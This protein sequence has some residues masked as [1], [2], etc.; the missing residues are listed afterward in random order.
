MRGIGWGILF[1]FAAS[2]ASADVET[3]VVTARPPD[4]VGNDAFS[5]AKIDAPALHAFEQLDRA[6]EQVPGLSEFRRDSCFSANPTTQGVSLRSIAPSGA[7]RTLV[8]LDG[9]PQ[10]DPFGGWVLWCSLPPEDI[11]A[12][13]VVR[14]AGAGPYG[15]GALTGTIAL[16]EADGAGLYAV[17]GSAGA[18]GLK[19]IAA[20]GGVNVGPLE[21]FGGGAEEATSGWTPVS[22]NQRGAADDDVSVDARNGSLRVAAAPGGGIEVSA[23]TSVYDESRHSGLVGAR[24]EASGVTASVTVLHPQSQGDLGWRL[25]GWLRDTDFANSSVSIGPLRAF[26]TPTNDEYATP[27]IGWGANGEL[28]GKLAGIDWA[29]GFD[30]RDASGETREHFNVAAGQFTM[31]RVAGGRTFVGGLYAEAANRFDGWLLTLGV[32]GDEWASTGGHLRQN[33]ISSGVVT[34]NQRFPSRS[35]EVFTAR[36]GIRKDF[37]GFYLRAAGYEGF[38]PPTLNELYRPFRLGNNFT[39]A[40][41][42][43]VPEALYGAELGIGSAVDALTWNATVFWN[44]L[45]DGVTNVTIGHGPGVFPAP[46]G[47]IPAG[48]LVIQRQNVGDID[49][50]GIEADAHYQLANN[51]GLKAAFDL[52]DAHVYGGAAQPQLTGKRPAQAPRWTVTAGIDAQPIDDITLYADLRFETDRFADDQNTLRLPDATEVDAKVAWSFAP[53]WALYVAAD[54]LL[55]ARIATTESADLIIN[56]DFPRILRAGIQFRR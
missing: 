7:S 8:T 19:R 16:D 49:A 17:D 47:F 3:V 22:P 55:N 36:G 25:Q 15:A 21:L 41:A 18:I 53:S 10:N 46:A 5:V 54:N 12:A 14:G 35:G 43:L 31:N 30:V 20:S 23:R 50:Y 4:P 13:E 39:L 27:T 42:A 11:Q 29:T 24:S 40:N 52:V 33:V 1:L 44:K 51:I 56:Y 6:L 37:D 32:R 45:H 26:T 2:A 38:R 9:V 28:R 34:L 48:G